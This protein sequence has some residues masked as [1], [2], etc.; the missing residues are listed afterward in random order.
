MLAVAAVA[1]FAG[2][3]QAVTVT[4]SVFTDT[5]TVRLDF[6]ELPPYEQI[7]LEAVEA[8]Y[9]CNCVDLKNPSTLEGTGFTV[10]A[11]NLEMKYEGAPPPS[12]N[13]I[14]YHYLDGYVPTGFESVEW[15]VVTQSVGDDLRLTGD[16]PLFVPEPS[17]A[18]LCLIGLVTI[19]VA[20]R[21][22]RDA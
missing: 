22:A 18:M 11:S 16:R 12:T 2:A 21:S 10:N 17:T 19:S 6:T 3:A 8:L 13:Y 1:F 15:I 20:K 5:Q 14:I 4:T 7:R 9:W